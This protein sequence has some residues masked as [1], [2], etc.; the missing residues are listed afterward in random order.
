M[1]A[2]GEGFGIDRTGVALI[3]L[4]ALVITPATMLVTAWVLSEGVDLA[5]ASAFDLVGAV[6]C[7]LL[8]LYVI[9]V[10]ARE[11]A[12]ALRVRI[13][14]RGVAKGNVELAW[15]EVETLAA[16]KFGLLELGGNGKRV[17]LRTYLYDDR[18]KLLEFIA[19]Q[20]G[21]P[22]PELTNSY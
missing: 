10:T 16:P 5:A 22:V 3:V 13:D 17:L 1:S 2:S 12:G 9:R 7:C 20:T 21:K 18:T 8:A 6:L 4:I 15:T 11:L 14:E 19:R